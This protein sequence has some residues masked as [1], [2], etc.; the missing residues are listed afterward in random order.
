MNEVLQINRE[1]NYRIIQGKNEDLIIL[2]QKK[3]RWVNKEYIIL[4][5]TPSIVET[6]IKVITEKYNF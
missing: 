3:N 2:Q 4:C 5:G 6:K 1:G